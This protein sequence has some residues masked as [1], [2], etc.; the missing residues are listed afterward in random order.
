MVSLVSLNIFGRGRGGGRGLIC[1][2]YIFLVQV[3]AWLLVLSKT[4]LGFSFTLVTHCN[5]HT[6]SS[7]ASCLR[8]LR[9]E[10][11]VFMAGIVKYITTVAVVQQC[12]SSNLLKQP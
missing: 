7:V 11:L 2:E 12:S 6:S 9:S 3:E 4:S 1:A 5:V 10:A 8:D